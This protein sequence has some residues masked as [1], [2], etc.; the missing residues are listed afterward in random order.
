ML[1]NLWRL[2]QIRHITGRKDKNSRTIKKTSFLKELVEN[3]DLHKPILNKIKTANKCAKYDF[4]APLKCTKHICDYVDSVCCDKCDEW[5]HKGCAKL[6][7]SEKIWRGFNLVQGKNEI[8]GT[9]LIW[10]S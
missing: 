4:V 5:I 3:A 9:D 6:P 7:Y 10:H 8:I 2:H 1:Q